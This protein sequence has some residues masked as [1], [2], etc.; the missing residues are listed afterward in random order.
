MLGRWKTANECG[1]L[2]SD[3]MVVS[4]RS[5][6]RWHDLGWSSRF[7][8]KREAQ[9]R[10]KKI[11]FY[12]DW[13][14]C[15]QFPSTASQHRAAWNAGLLPCLTFLFR[16]PATHFYCESIYLLRISTSTTS[17]FFGSREKYHSQSSRQRAIGWLQ[18]ETNWIWLPSLL[19]SHKAGFVISHTENDQKTISGKDFS[20]GNHKCLLVS[21]LIA[22]L[23]NQ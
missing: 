10:N 3:V 17:G 18:L 22:M 13:Q 20:E 16:N 12:G 11:A 14:A 5:R 1:S 23:T 2:G 19:H 9:C 7:L 8:E 21:F 4:Q 15:W 6:S